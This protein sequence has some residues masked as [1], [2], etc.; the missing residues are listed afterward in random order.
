MRG[1]WAACVV[2]SA[3]AVAG[4]ILGLG[5]RDR[6]E[7]PVR[8][9]NGLGLVAVTG[10][11][12]S[13]SASNRVLRAPKRRLLGRKLPSNRVLLA[14]TCLLPAVFT[15]S[16]SELLAGAPEALVPTATAAEAEYCPPGEPAAGS[17]PAPP[18]RRR[19][20]TEGPAE[21]APEGAPLLPVI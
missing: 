15:F 14:A 8:Y 2:V 1:A 13:L 16:R 12:L 5:D 3:A 19:P 6:L 20:Q 7:W 9:T 17:A 21:G 4:S 10:A 11:L 18:R